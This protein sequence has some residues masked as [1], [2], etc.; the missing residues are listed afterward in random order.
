MRE[1]I[2][3]ILVRAPNWIGDAVLCLPALEALKMACPQ[4][5]ITVL[6]KPWV[7]PVFFNNPSVK[8]V[9]DYDIS[10]RHRGIFGK[11][12][13][14][15]DIRKYGFDSAVLFQNAFEAAMIVFMAGIPVRI[16]Y[17]RDLRG[18][19]LTNPIKLTSDIKKTHH[20]FYYLN[21]V[22]GLKKDYSRQLSAISHQPKIYLTKEES[23]YAKNF[24]KGKGIESNIIVG[25]APGASYGP[26]KRWMAERFTE[27]ARRL[28]ADY[29]AGLILFGGIDDKVICGEVLKGLKGLNLAG[30]VGLRQTIAL[31]SR[32]N[33]FITNDS[34]PMH[35][36]ASL[37]IPVV[38]VFG[39]TDPNLTAPLSD[40]VRVVKKDIECSPCFDRVCREGH[41]N[42]MKLVGTDDVYES[43]AALLEKRAV[44]E[45]PAVFLDRDG[46][47]NEDTG[48][49]DSPERLIIIDGVSSAIRELN[50]RGFKVVII[51]NQ[52]GV[53]RGYFTKEAV[54]AVNKRLEEILIK[55]GAHID[56]IY[57][58]PHHPDD[59]CECR[60]PRT[61]LLQMAKDDLD[62]DF[63]K[64]YVVGDKL[65]DVEIAQNIG[66]KGILVLTG[67]GK[68]ERK[69]INH[70][71]SHIANDLR[72][73]VEWIIKDS[74][75]S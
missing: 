71:P 60:K 34:G 68:D 44:K 50:S 18:F 49:I 64:S 30:E 47:I 52:S 46:T 21:I 72:D 28:M 33:L 31:I 32:C 13:L 58:C 75:K 67:M 3:N 29:D 7:G 17:A 10:G 37:G 12:K 39:S 26:A 27:V 70:R 20:V 42:C 24:L 57:Y 54:D 51:T 69:K 14:I 15:K 5:A 6:A 41:Y 45:F 8:Q 62:I 1:G 4:A 66:S 73:A 2:N 74:L 56:G 11:W 61:G 35:I 40:N 59:N 65:S 63:K 38:A 25:I 55:E 19:L 9:I 16:G 23:E 53:A 43:A 48:Y 22:A 36:A